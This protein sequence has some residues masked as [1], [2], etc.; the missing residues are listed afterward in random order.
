MKLYIET[1]GPKE[2]GLDGVKREDFATEAEYLDAAT[3]RQMELDNPEYKKARAKVE[4]EHRQRLAKEQEEQDAAEYKAAVKACKLSD[5]D[6]NAIKKTATEMAIRD[7]N[8]GKIKWDEVEARGKR[9]IDQLSEKKKREIVT[10]QR[11]NA[12]LRGN[13]FRVN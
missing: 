1:F 6:M 3:R 10:N 2:S 9:Y 8:D 12:A 11:V 4:Q 13:R 7:Y 5:T